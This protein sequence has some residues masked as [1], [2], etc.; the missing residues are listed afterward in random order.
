MP[1]SQKT[2]AQGKQRL[3]YFFGFAMEITEIREYFFNLPILITIEANSGSDEAI[4]R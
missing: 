2:T 3:Q 4:K 1:K